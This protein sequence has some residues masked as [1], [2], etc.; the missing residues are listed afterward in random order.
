MKATIND[1]A[2][3]S[4]FSI[5]TVSLALSD[6]PNRISARTREYVREVAE[7]LNYIP[8]QAAVSLATN[9]SK[10]IGFIADDFRNSFI[11]ANYMTVQ[12]ALQ[13]T[14]YFLLA[15]TPVGNKYDTAGCIRSL[16]SC[17]IEGLI[18]TQSE[19]IGKERENE[20]IYKMLKASGIP[21][22]SCDHNG[23]E[24]LGAGVNCD[25]KKGGYIATKYFLEL[26]Y[27]DIACVTGTDSLRVTQDRIDGYK[28]AL[29]E[30]DVPYCPDLLF[31]GDYTMESGEQA[32]PY[33]LGKGIRAV[34]AFN[35]QIAFGLYR[36]ARKYSIKI[37]QDL[38]IIGFDN[39]PY[40]DVLDTPLTSVGFDYKSIGKEVSKRIV[41]LIEDLENEHKANPEIYTYEPHLYVRA[42]TCRF[43]EV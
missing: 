24:T 14:G 26:G 21:V 6:K 39:I 9:R 22:L 29:A 5:A 8:S 20:E 25:Y 41:S 10:L 18:Y 2:R 1:I 19:Q 37:P 12:Q 31:H 42:S 7:R 16:L 40:G 27:R 15:L 13:E 36:A 3:E 4:G 33:L 35:D 38:S 43:C 17:G 34:F 28:E 23:F 11:A 30:F 32:L